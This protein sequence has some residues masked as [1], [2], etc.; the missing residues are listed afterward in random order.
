M[1]LVPVGHSASPVIKSQRLIR[2]FDLGQEWRWQGAGHER[3][4]R[5]GYKLIRLN[6]C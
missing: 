2:I 4:K 3:F 6:I 1:I 5:P